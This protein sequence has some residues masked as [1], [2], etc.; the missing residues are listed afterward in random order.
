MPREIISMSPDEIRAFVK[1]EKR[2]ILA[3][4]AE[5]GAPWSDAAVFLLEGDRVF[6]RIPR[7]SRSYRNI[8]RDN[9]VC[10]IIERGPP[11]YYEI[12]GVMAHGQAQE[13][14]D[15][16]QA[17]QIA[18]RLAAQ[19]DPVASDAGDGAVFSIPLLEDVVSFDFSKIQR[20]H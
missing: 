2:L 17:L 15:G 12:M 11:P 18:A 7:S 10:C 1:G 19:R 6:F 20:R 5:D 9:R 3:T 4:L 14:R 16:G 13:V 8:R